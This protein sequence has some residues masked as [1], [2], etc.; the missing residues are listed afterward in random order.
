MQA[1]NW[2]TS[3]SSLYRDEGIV[4]N[5]EW[6]NQYN[7]ISSHEDESN[8]IHNEQSVIVNENGDN[9]E[10]NNVRVETEDEWSEDEAE[11]AGVTDTMLTSSDF[12]EDNERQHIVNVAPA[13]G[14][15]IFRDKYSKELAYPGIFLGQRRPEITKQVY[16]SDICKSEL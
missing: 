5:S 9:V 6:A 3:N 10:S 1:A 4:L 14:N 15:S 13:E 16:Y 7:E 2:L 11:P 12:L 8:D